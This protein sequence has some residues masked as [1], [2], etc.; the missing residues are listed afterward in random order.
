MV[1]YNGPVRTINWECGAKRSRFFAEFEINLNAV[2]DQCSFSDCML[3]LWMARRGQPL[4]LVF[5]MTY[6]NKNVL[7]DSINNDTILLPHVMQKSCSSI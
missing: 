2:V 7:L 1:Q 4:M 3:I 5:C 6:I